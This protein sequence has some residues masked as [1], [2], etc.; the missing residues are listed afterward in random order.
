MKCKKVLLALTLSLCALLCMVVTASASE[1]PQHTDHPICGATHTDI[2]DHTGT[3]G[4]V[5]WTAWDGND[6]DA[7]TAD[8][9]LTAGHYYLSGNVTPTST[10]HVVGQ[11][12]L[13]LNGYT[14]SYSG[15]VSTDSDSVGGM[16]LLDN[17][18]V[19]N[20]CDCKGS[21]SIVY[22]YDS[23]TWRKSTVLVKGMST[24]NLYGG[25]VI[26]EKGTTTMAVDLN[27]YAGANFHM[28]GGKVENRSTQNAYN[29]YAVYVGG[30]PGAQVKSSDVKLYGG[31][32]GSKGYGIRVFDVSPSILVAGGK[33]ESDNTAIAVDGASLTLQGKPII[34]TTKD[35]SAAIEVGSNNIKVEDSFA[36]TSPVS[37]RGT[38][39]TFGTAYSAD[40]AQYFTS[41]EDGKFVA[42]DSAANTLYL[43][44][45][46]IIQQP[47]SGNSYTV[48]G[49]APDS[50]LSYQWYVAKKGEITV[51]DA[52]AKK[53]A[54]VSY[55]GGN[56][57]GWSVK[58]GDKID[59]FT[60][61]MNE[62]DVLTLSNITGGTVSE[63]SIS[64]T[65][66]EK[67]G[68]TYTFTAPAAGEY[69][70][71]ISATERNDYPGGH[72]YLNFK[73]ALQ[74]FV[75]DTDKTAV[76]TA[77]ALD[78][79]GLSAGEY[80][81]QVTWEGKSTVN[82][83]VV[84][85]SGSSQQPSTGGGYSSAP[86][87]TAVLNGPNKSATDYSGGDY[88]LIFRAAASYSGFT[89]VQ[90]D[91]KTL[92]ASNYTVE[93]NGGAEVYLK[94]VYLRTLA[95]GKHTV[96]IL[97]AAGNVSMDFTVGGTADA[98][99][100]FDA[101]VGVYA[102]TAVLSLTGLA[103]TGKKRR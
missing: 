77:A 7:T 97:S 64:G 91:G 93:D 35:G 92:A 17:S 103:Y 90:V 66:V 12:Y 62:G 86:T 29:T 55:W 96:T 72:P 102:V 79:A 67:D 42:Y 32:L 87:V 75:P 19:L 18:A 84:Q 65:E 44:A 60:L 80:I 3:C 69:T 23:D 30:K 24:L 40:K 89:G 98:P 88:G 13:C 21:G 83:G 6:M 2:G 56:W 68:R 81:C 26:K 85:F 31:E 59:C 1:L 14:L 49:N 48:K 39:E 45:C 8:V 5:T 52:V 37:V 100:T 95:A 27:Y 11:V 47:T 58:C 51:T 9:Q 36:P 73:A 61:Y 43:T 46:A 82:S 76:G 25:S 70:L 28:Y 22:D 53:S 10:I 94:A 101:G 63:V 54:D 16:I 20:I 34:K 99:K 41:F 74:T 15:R 57:N 78:T 38:S 50:K 33:I 4:S 71:K